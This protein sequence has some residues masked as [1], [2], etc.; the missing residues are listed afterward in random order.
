[1]FMPFGWF[2]AN[3]V[4]PYGP[5]RRPV[6]VPARYRMVGVPGAPAMGWGLG[7]AIEPGYGWFAGGHPIGG[8][9]GTSYRGV[10]ASTFPLPAIY[11][12]SG[13]PLDSEMLRYAGA[14]LVAPIGAGGRPIH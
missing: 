14:P 13:G 8:P 6:P 9:S 4:M 5:Y 12:G 10:S 11:L 1:M 2:P 3:P 7:P